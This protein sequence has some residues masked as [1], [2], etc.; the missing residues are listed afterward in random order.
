MD[1][2]EYLDIIDKKGYLWKIDQEV[3]WNLEAACIGGMMQRVGNGRCGILFNNIKGYYPDKGRIATNIHTASWKIPWRALTIAMKL[4]EDISPAELSKEYHRRFRN[5]IKP[6]EMAA[7]DAPCKEVIKIG[8]EASLLD[9]PIPMVHMLD[10][11]RYS[12]LHGFIN[13]DPDTGWTNIGL[14]RVMVKGPRQW[15][16]LF[17]P[18]GHASN[19]HMMKYEMRG[20]TMPCAVAIGLDPIILNTACGQ[21]PTGVCEY[22]VAGGLAGEPMKLV[23]AE[24]NNL[25]VPAFAEIIIEGEVRP[26]ERTDE[27][28]FGEIIG[29]T[30][31]RNSSP[32]FRVTAITTRKNPIIPMSVEGLKMMDEAGIAGLSMNAGLQQ[33]FDALGLPIRDNSACYPTIMWAISVDPATP[34]DLN[35]CAQ[36]YFSHKTSIWNHWLALVDKD[37]SVLEWRDTYEAIGL[38]ADPRDL[39]KHTSDMD[40]FCHP[41]FFFTDVENR[42][43]GTDS[44]KFYYDATTKFKDPRFIPRKDRFEQAFPEELQE[45]LKQKW[46]KLGFDEPWEDVRDYV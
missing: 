1:M 45:R 19:I 26:G 23:R 42:F 22:D 35:D 27:G 40:A 44:A 30:H 43:K 12:T 36:A 33:W 31:G 25:L 2:R 41:L 15:A 34:A 6:I 7:A 21:I 16:S 28:P 14:Y 10:G 32:I 3:D 38:N 18:S 9:L 13:Q 11:G 39:K 24:T 5:P 17:T 4:P 8:K 46:A 29:Y 20:N 37:V